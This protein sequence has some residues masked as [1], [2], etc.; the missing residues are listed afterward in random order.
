MKSKVEDWVP[1]CNPCTIDLMGQEFGFLKRHI[2]TRDAAL[3]SFRMRCYMWILC[4]DLQRTVFFGRRTTTTTKK[5]P[6]VTGP[7]NR[8]LLLSRT[9]DWNFRPVPYAD[10]WSETKIKLLFRYVSTNENLY[11]N[12]LNNNYKW[13][14]ITW[15]NYRKQ[16]G[17]AGRKACAPRIL[18][19]RTVWKRL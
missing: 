14:Q 19:N 18:D 10:M 17:T 16:P 2:G 13:L 6:Q 5:T 4:M 1:F 15:G 3:G 7:E 8:K 11:W 9:L 12:E